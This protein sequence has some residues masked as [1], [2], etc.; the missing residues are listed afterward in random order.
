MK[1]DS[2]L[3][4]NDI[5][6][7]K[8]NIVSINLQIKIEKFYIELK[9]NYEKIFSSYPDNKVIQNIDTIYK[10]GSIV[11]KE[12]M[13]LMELFDEYKSIIDFIS[14][15]EPNEKICL[16]SNVYQ[17]IKIHLDNMKIKIDDMLSNIFL[18]NTN[19]SSSFY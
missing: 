1:N 10:R 14:E 12:I 2:K 6:L 17:Q 4:E 15:I 18:Y 3:I 8:A 16:E 13:R 19:I 11:F 9:N 7:Q 5:I